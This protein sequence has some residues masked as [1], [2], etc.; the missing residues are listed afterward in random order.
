VKQSFSDSFFKIA[1]IAA[2]GLCV[3]TIRDQPKLGFDVESAIDIL[4][5][6]GYNLP[7]SELAMELLKDRK[8]LIT[9]GINA[10]SSRMIIEKLLILNSRDPHAAI[11]L[12]IRTEGGW[13]ADAFS[14][15]DTIRTIEAPVNIHAIGDVHSSGLMILTAGTGDRIV[16]E[17]TIL[18]YHALE[19]DDGNL[20]QD[21]YQKIWNDYSELPADWITQKDGSFNYF[22][23][24]EAIQYSVADK[25]IESKTVGLPLKTIK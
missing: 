3:Y 9:T 8:I 7:E 15:I 11:S 25:L 10:Q 22:T 23:A 18:G 12:Y 20:W 5:D 19:P 2:L 24:L 1:V 6:S 4:V 13:E 21:R 16:Y 17:N 14:V